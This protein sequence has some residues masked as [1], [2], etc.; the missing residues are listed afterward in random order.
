[1]AMVASLVFVL[2]YMAAILVL[3]NNGIGFSGKVLSLDQMDRTLKTILFVEIIYY[4]CVNSI[5]VSILFFYLRIGECLLPRRRSG[6]WLTSCKPS[7]R[8]SEDS[9]NG[10]SISWQPFA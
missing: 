7:K 4:L 1:M 9:V 10:V 8:L 6:K 2:G 3:R 5:K